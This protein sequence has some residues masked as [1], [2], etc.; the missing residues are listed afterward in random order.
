MGRKNHE[1][2]ESP[3]VLPAHLVQPE[4]VRPIIRMGRTVEEAELRDW[5][6]QIFTANPWMA[7]TTRNVDLI[8]KVFL[9]DARM[10]PQ[11]TLQDLIQ[12][13][14]I[15]DAEQRPDRVPPPPK[16]QFPDDDLTQPLSDG[17]LPLP[18]DALPHEQRRASI[19]QMRNLVARLRNFEVR[20]REQQQ[21]E[22][23]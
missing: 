7:F 10:S 5:L 6:Q 16:P 23:Q 3:V 19:A 2:E 8:S 11:R 21:Q 9:F 4:S 12:A 17:N 22:P 18:L 20:Q 14:K 1:S 15:T 13:V